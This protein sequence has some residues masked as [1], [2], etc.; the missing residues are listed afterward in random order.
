MAQEPPGT[1][2][3]IDLRC[4]CP[5]ADTRPVQCEKQADGEDGLC[6]DCRENNCPNS[7]LAQ[8]IRS[9]QELVDQNLDPVTFAERMDEVR[10]RLAD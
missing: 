7:R 1:T 9:F 8:Y 6:S 2:G 5:G 10:Q 3:V 4:A